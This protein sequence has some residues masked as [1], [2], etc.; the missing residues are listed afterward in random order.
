MS[1]TGCRMYVLGS[2]RSGVRAL[3]PE[4]CS[5]LETCCTA[6]PQVTSQLFLQY[7][8]RRSD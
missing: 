5:H 8:G 3:G 2:V 7:A 6:D 4:A 1:G